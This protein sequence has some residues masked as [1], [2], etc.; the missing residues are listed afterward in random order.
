[1]TRRPLSVAFAA[2]VAIAM[3]VSGWSA[4]HAQPTA[5]P[6]PWSAARLIVTSDSG[7]APLAVL[8]NGD[9][10]SLTSF[11]R[12]DPTNGIRAA[13]EGVFA[14]TPRAL[15]RLQRARPLDAV[16]ENAIRTRTAGVGPVPGRA[17]PASAALS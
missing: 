14:G 17:P 8:S 3:S 9:H 10:T 2:V 16:V 5:T 13:I 12:L 6:S 15:T 7:D 11:A 1:M 4:F